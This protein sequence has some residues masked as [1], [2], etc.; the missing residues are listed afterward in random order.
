MVGMRWRNC[1]FAHVETDDGI[2]GHRRGLAR[3]SAARPSR[4]RSS[5]SAHRYV[6]GRSAFPIEKLWHDIL[7][8][9]FMHRPIIN[10]AAAAIEMAMWDIVGKALD[11]PVYDLLGGRCTSACRPMPMPGTAQAKTAAE[12]APPRPRPRKGYRG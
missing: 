6:I 3:V 2:S 4:P 8:N 5:S 10:S 1:V 9:E 12:M 7:R 11:R